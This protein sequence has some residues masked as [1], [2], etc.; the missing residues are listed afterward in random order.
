MHIIFLQHFGDL[1]G[2]TGKSSFTKLICWGL[3]GVVWVHL[4]LH[5]APLACLWWPL[6]AIGAPFV[7]FGG[8]LGC[9]WG[10]LGCLW[11]SLGLTLRITLGVIFYNIAENIYF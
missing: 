1:I 8:P 7:A 5:W 6:V 4:E 10:S 3:A 9:L 11:V 2:D